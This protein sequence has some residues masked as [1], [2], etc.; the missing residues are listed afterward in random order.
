L[1]WPKEALLEVAFNFLGTVE[2]LA[3]ITGAPRVRIKIYIIDRK[4]NGLRIYEL[5]SAI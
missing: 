5:V 2:V 4:Y 1:D 3:T